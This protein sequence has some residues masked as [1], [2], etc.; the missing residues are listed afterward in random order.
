MRRELGFEITACDP[1]ELSAN[2]DLAIGAL[3]VGA[4]GAIA[5]VAPALP[6]TL[7]SIPVTFSP[8]DEQV[9]RIRAFS[10]PSI[11]ALVSISEYLIQT[12]RALLAPVLG[13]RHTMREYLLPVERP[14]SLA[15]ADLVICDSI[16]CRRIEHKNS[17]TYKVISPGCLEEIKDSMG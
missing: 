14:G 10:E 2:P 3:V 9:E 15:A 12:A 17:T 11:V 5:D 8:A 13:S 1:G 6:R 16:T 4:P 7:P